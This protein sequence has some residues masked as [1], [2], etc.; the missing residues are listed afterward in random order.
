MLLF[1]SFLQPNDEPQGSGKSLTIITPFDSHMHDSNEASN[2]MFGDDSMDSKDDDAL[3]IDESLKSAEKT[4][5][6]KE[7]QKGQERNA[8]D[9]SS[10][11]SNITIDQ[12]YIPETQCENGEGDDDSMEYIKIRADTNSC[13]AAIDQSQ[14][15][16]E[17][18]SYGLIL[19]IDTT[20]NNKSHDSINLST[21]L[22]NK[23]DDPDLEMSALK[24][25]ESDKSALLQKSQNKAGNATSS[26]PNNDR[27]FSITPDLDEFIIGEAKYNGNEKGNANT[28]GDGRTSSTPEFLSAKSTASSKTD[29]N[30]YESP[31]HE[32]IS[33]EQIETHVEHANKKN[34]EPAENSGSDKTV[35]EKSESKINAENKDIPEPST[36]KYHNLVPIENEVGDN[37]AE[38]AQPTVDVTKSTDNQENEVD[39][40]Y[41][42]ATQAPPILD[43]G[44][45]TDNQVLVS[46]ENEV[47]DFYAQATQAPPTVDAGKSTANQD[48]VSAENEVD[49]IY[50][51]AT[52]APPE[53]EV[54]S[55]EPN[56]LMPPP[57][58]RKKFN[59]KQRLTAPSPNTIYELATQEFTPPENR[60][61]E[62]DKEH[63]EQVKEKGSYYT[64]KDLFYLLHKLKNF[65]F[66]MYLKPATMAKMTIFMK[67]Q[68]KYSPKHRKQVLR[69]PRN[70]IDLLQ[71]VKLM[72]LNYPKPLN[73]LL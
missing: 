57:A 43:A 67:Y 61:K 6:E 40:F 23:L 47:D 12:S 17:G 1:L 66:Q 60:P 63:V 21:S 25:N 64:N 24:W 56:N 8:D 9:S 18:Y 36:S 46:A 30:N 10:N 19:E 26:T 33:N 44:N 11:E 50:A 34:A 53:I 69:N 48:L 2:D 59:F 13:S 70:S 14:N 65:V 22:V 27:C 35:G 51:Q 7:I 71:L 41:A 31:A 29:E 55:K 3:V 5:E 38:A 58:S 20:K 62:L 15:I 32:S 45:S 39:D 37:T 68:L 16:M 54:A 42:Q 28:S 73:F 49:D 52:Q 72:I 4:A